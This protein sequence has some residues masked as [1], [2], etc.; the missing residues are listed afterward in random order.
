MS[1]SGEKISVQQISE[2]LETLRKLRSWIDELLKLVPNWMDIDSFE[3]IAPEEKKNRAMFLAMRVFGSSKASWNAV[4]AAIPVESTDQENIAWY[5]NEFPSIHEK[6]RDLVMHKLLLSWDEE[7]DVSA[8]ATIAGSEKKIKFAFQQIAHFANQHLNQF[9]HPF[10]WEAYEHHVEHMNAPLCQ[11]IIDMPYFRPDEWFENGGF[12]PVTFNAKLE[13]IPGNIRQR[14]QEIRDSFIFGNWAAVIALSRCLL[15]YAF[16]EKAL[17]FKIPK[18]NSLSAFIPH[19]GKHF[20]ELEAGM[21]RIQ[22]AGNHVMHVKPNPPPLDKE[23][24][25]KCVDDITE[26]VSALYS[27]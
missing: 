3:E 24:A 14:I 2:N 21:W 13:N 15:E 18:E 19:F 1:N 23:H 26:I 6:T 17:A 22:K 11:I 16:E 27:E 20:R 9:L 7:E 12:P 10:D 4:P 25:K 8:R 5:K